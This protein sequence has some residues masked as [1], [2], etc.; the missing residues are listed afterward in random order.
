MEKT[1]I[2][3]KFITI[4]SILEVDNGLEAIK[5]IR[6]ELEDRLLIISN[7]FLPKLTGIEVAK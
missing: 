3:S 4:Y 7:I 1:I 5:L 2:I 6:K